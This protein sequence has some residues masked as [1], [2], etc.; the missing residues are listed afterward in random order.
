MAPF[1]VFKVP[2]F[3]V[4]EPKSVASG[5]SFLLFTDGNYGLVHA[6]VGVLNTGFFL[7]GV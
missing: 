5:D 2:F 6:Y 3:N 4:L 7:W 1:F